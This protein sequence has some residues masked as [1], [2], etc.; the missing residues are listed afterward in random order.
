M[1]RVRRQGSVAELA[2]RRR[3]WAMGLRFRVENRLPGKPDIVFPTQK[4][5][6]FVDGDFWHGNAWRVRRL[7]T[8]ESQ[9]VNRAEWW[10]AKIKRNVER[11]R[12]VSRQLE[13]LGWR[14]VRVWESDVLADPDDVSFRLARVVRPWLQVPQRLPPSRLERRRLT[15]VTA[16]EYR[17]QYRVRASV[18][19]PESDPPG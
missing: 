13:E 7:P 18:A 6:I 3:L 12:E 2:I 11:D 14:V 10:I 9:F 15:S 19:E 1:S 17:E 8:F 16:K 5:A 4:L